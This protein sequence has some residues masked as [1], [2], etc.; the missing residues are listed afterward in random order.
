[1]EIGHGG[2][3]LE[4]AYPKLP[5]LWLDTEGSEAEVFALPA[6]ALG[7]LKTT[8]RGKTMRAVAGS[9]AAM[10]RRQS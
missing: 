2:A 10:P 6:S 8:K 1:M 5:F 3:T 7:S 9:A 4:L